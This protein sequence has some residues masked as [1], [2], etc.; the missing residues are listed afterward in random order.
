VQRQLSSYQQ[1]LAQASTKASRL[2][3]EHT[4]SS[5]SSA[6]L[7]A[8]LRRSE[9]LV[10][11]LEERRAVLQAE[12]NKLQQQC[13]SMQQQVGSFFCPL[14][15]P[16]QR[17]PSEVCSVHVM[18]A[19]RMH[20]HPVCILAS[21][22]PFIGWLTLLHAVQVESLQLAV[23]QQSSRQQ[24]SDRSSEQLRRQLKQSNEQQAVLLH[25]LQEAEQVRCFIC[26]SACM[27]FRLHGTNSGHGTTD[28]EQ[29]R[30]SSLQAS[31]I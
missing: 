3:A 4:A 16:V 12:K 11:R 28:V 6:Q 25:Q 23:Q 31:A 13:S 24:A 14:S 27:Q 10:S 2:Q 26:S 17:I 20:G 30:S 15:A 19:Q 7:E 18:V 21:P 22:H 8:K 9:G 1:Q 29:H 5:D